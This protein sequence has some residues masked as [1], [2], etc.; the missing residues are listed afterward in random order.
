MSY[1]NESGKSTKDGNPEKN[2]FSI[3]YINEHQF[4]KPATVLYGGESKSNSNVYSSYQPLNSNQNQMSNQN[5]IFNQNQMSNQD[6]NQNKNQHYTH[7]DRLKLI[8]TNHLNNEEKKSVLKLCKEFESI[9]H[10]EGDMLTSTT[11]IQHEIITTSPVPIATKTYRYPEIHKEEVNNQISK[12]LKQGIIRPSTSPWSSPLWVVPK[13]KDASGKTKWRIV[14]D[15]R[16]LNDVT[17]GDS[18]PLPNITE[19]LDQLGHSKYFTTLDLASGFF[20]VPMCER[21]ISKTAFSTPSGLFEHTK[22]PMGLKN[23]PRTFSRLMNNVLT[24]LQ[25]LYC[26]VY[27]D[28]IVI[29]ANSIQNHEEKLKAVFQRLKDNNLKIQPD[30][31]EFMRKEVAYL[32]HI[33]SEKGVSPN[34][35]KTEVIKNFPVPRN[36]KEI[37]SFLGLIGYYHKFIPQFSKISKP[38]TGLLKKDK[39]FIWSEEQQTAFETLRDILLS[40]IILQYPDFTKDFIVTTDASNHSVGAI[41]SQGEIGQD[42]PI[43]YASRTLNSAEGNYN[44]TEKELLAIIWAVKHFRPYIYG[45]KFKIVTDHRA[46]TWL[47]NVKDPGSKLIRWRLQ[48]E[49]YDYQIVHKPGRVNSNA[50][51]LSRIPIHSIEHDIIKETYTDYINFYLNEDEPK[52]HNFSETD[53]LLF[54]SKNTHIAYPTSIDLSDENPFSIDALTKSDEIDSLL[55]EPKQ[56]YQIYTTKTKNQSIFHCMTKYNH[57]DNAS[58]KDI[59]LTLQNL[60]EKIIND[61]ISTIHLPNFENQFDKL[62]FDKIKQIIK[63]LFRDLKINIIICHN[64]IT[65]PNESQIPII[66]KENHDSPAA[67]HCGIARMYTRLKSKYKWQS[68]KRD[69]EN[70]IRNCKSCQINKTARKKQKAPLVITTTSTHA[71]QRVAMDIVGILPETVNKNKYILTFQDDL[72]KFSQ[73]FA[74]PNHEAKEVAKKLFIFISLYGIPRTILTDQG[75]EFTSNLLKEMSQLFKIKHLT[76]TAYHPQTNGALERSHSTLKDYLKHYIST[77]QNDWDEYLPSYIYSYNCSI[78]STTNFSP[79]ELVFGTKPVLPSSITNLNDNDS[80]YNTYLQDLKY[81]INKSL[82]YARE[83]IINSKEKTKRR[84]DSKI[85]NPSYKI[86]DNV[87]ITNENFRLSNKKLSPNWKGPYTIISTNTRTANVTI[88]TERGKN[89]RIHVNR[90]KPAYLPISSTPG[91]TLRQRPIKNK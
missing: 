28:D 3:S 60:R 8:R 86:G 12:M 82:S 81:R 48:L 77:D 79:H 84:Y 11:A 39:P 55:S 36:P 83:N 26:F 85:I 78:H 33:I 1:L 29:Y 31:C 75:S 45:R 35:E 23:A 50:D 43:S 64:K 73:A 51:C 10:A 32:G 80:N 57:Y 66:L 5:Q 47:F 18:Y 38:L 19:I 61:K 90:I 25:G 20:Q 42:L 16:K 87:F 58:Y 91:R 53:N 34:P 6:Q 24:G 49:E 13:K 4:G 27:L 14:I 52:M 30:K 46:L 71:F 37:K 17:V 74:I 21:D 76:S 72:T 9:I 67:G 2:S 63:Y 44:T 56:I 68:M 69:V 88:R 54:D 15:Y 41:L 65:N 70:Y 22:M 59:F 89:V 62:S 7:I 40:P